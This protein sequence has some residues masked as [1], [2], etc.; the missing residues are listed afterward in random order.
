MAVITAVGTSLMAPMIRRGEIENPQDGDGFSRTT[1]R[2]AFLNFEQEFIFG[3]SSQ[4]VTILAAGSSVTFPA[5][6][7]MVGLL[8]DQGS[9]LVFAAVGTTTDQFMEIR[10]DGYNTATGLCVGTVLS[11]AGVGSSYSQWVAYRSG[12][13]VQ[14]TQPGQIIGYQITRNASDPDHD[15][16]ISAGVIRSTD[17]T[18]DIYLRTAMTKRLDATFV[19][20]TG[21]GSQVL[22]ANLAGT[23]TTALTAVTGTG[24][25]FLTDFS[26][27]GGTT[28]GPTG[29]CSV[30]TAGGNAA[31]VYTI[32]SNTSLV[33]FIVSLGVTG[34]TYQR[35]G[36][37]SGA[38]AGL[39][40]GYYVVAGFNPLTG[41]VQ[42][43]TASVNPSGVPDLP[44]GYTKYG[45]V[46]YAGITSGAIVSVSGT[47]ASVPLSLLAKQGR[48]TTQ[49]GVPVPP[50]SYS[51]QFLYFQPYQESVS[52]VG[53]QLFYQDNTKSPAATIP[54]A[55][56]DVFYWLDGSNYR[57]SRGPVYVNRSSTV[58]ISIA[59]AAVFTW[60]AHGLKVGDP[61]PV[62]TTTGA[63]PAN[64]AGIQLYVKTVLTANTFT[65]SA[66]QD[67]AAISTTGNTQSGVH[68]AVAGWTG[69]RGTGAGT[70]ELS[71]DQSGFYANKYAITN[72][73]GAYQGVYVGTVAT[74]AVGAFAFE[75]GA[76]AAGATPGL[77]GVWNYFNRLN[78]S[79]L[80]GESANSWT[81]STKTWRPANAMSKM[82]IGF[83]IGIQEEFFTASHSAQTMSITGARYIG[84]G[85]DS[86]TAFTGL[87][88]ATSETSGAITASFATCSSNP[89]N[90]LHTVMAI[91]ANQAGATG[92]FYGDNNDPTFFQSGLTFSMRF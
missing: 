33:D 87:P 62:L 79:M 18:V 14:L 8:F 5:D 71:F 72:G 1:A 77:I 60:T 91:E 27:Y 7:G 55:L 47:T 45:I 40:T 76:I 10:S 37:Y 24:T 25:A 82:S 36:Y 51:N 73:P 16:D 81:Y 88:S 32:A 84:V 6:P 21:N 67:G 90:G 41:D 75:Y 46:G 13:Q 23:I 3:T 57:I 74:Q 53:V 83:V 42:I 30:I 44:S 54:F 66:T 68:T 70:S 49:D 69:V 43:F 61:F 63:L 50:T 64:V 38:S 19:A 56:Y 48:L 9:T 80:T 15:I 92:T 20:G 31:P 26:P 4:G 78:V 2:E 22:S 28:M 39:V 11:S 17:G 59:A 58:T 35:G 12:P 86:A 65:V 85:L 29:R 34:A 52:L 89:A